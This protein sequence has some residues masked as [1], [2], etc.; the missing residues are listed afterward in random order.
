M[1]GPVKSNRLAV[2]RSYNAYL[3]AL[4]PG[5]G[6]RTKQRNLVVARITRLDGLPFDGRESWQELIKRETGR[7]IHANRQVQPIIS[8]R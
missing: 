3:R 6:I 5:E 7:I 4:F 1:Q 2:D 8:T